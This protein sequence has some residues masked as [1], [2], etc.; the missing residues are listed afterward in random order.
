MSTP[1]TGVLGHA[2]FRWLLVARTVSIL[3]NAVAPIALAFAVLDLTGSP[4]DLG[5]VVAARSVANVAV[6]LFGGVIADRLPRDVVLVATSFGAALTQGAVAV[7]V[8]TG[9]ATVPLL[10][11]LSILNGAVAAVSLPTTA[12]MVP[13][14]VPESLLRPANAV[15]R[16][17]IN[18]GTIVGASAGAGMVALV[19]AGWGLAVD[20]AGF[21]VAAA[22]YARIRLPHRPAVAPAD[23]PSV[24]ADIREGWAEF[25]GRR[26]VWTV[27]AQ[28]AV[29]NAAFVGAT[30]VLG[31]V[32]ADASFGRAGW[33]LVV[34]AQTVGLALGALIALRWRPRH[35]LGIGVALMA[36]TALPV[37]A[38][39]GAPALPTLLVAFALGGVAIEL[40]AIAWDHALQS[41]VPRAVLSRVYSYDMVGSFVAVPLGEALVGPLA[42]AVGTPATLVG[43]AVVIVVATVVAASTRSVRRVT[44]EAALPV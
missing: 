21:A 34:A 5:L 20:A 23:R 41:N 17:S 1:T 27:V 37:L 35:A 31:P 33:G 40:F 18:A 15:I 19:G 32:V 28:F 25:S 22:L 10:V 3:G 16:L 43:C 14:T 13:E 36:V 29:L 24:I 44:T 26:W 7:L 42:H 11:V 2:P 39:A 12:A 6:L 8:L 30:T 9:T 4:V 38:L